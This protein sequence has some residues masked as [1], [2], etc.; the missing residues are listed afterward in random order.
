MI[1][2]GGTYVERTDRPFREEIFGSG[3]R[4]AI[5]LVAL[6]PKVRLISGLDAESRVSAVHIAREYSVDAEWIDR[7]EPVRFRYFTPL[8]APS[9]SGRLASLARDV[10]ASGDAALVFG[11]IE[12]PPRKIEV[13]R[14]VFDPQQPGDILGLDV[15]GLKAE[16]IAYVLNRAEASAVSK[17]PDTERAAVS[18]LRESR[19]E[20]V[21]VKCG[22]QGALLASLDGVAWIGAYPTEQVRPL[23]SGDVFAAGFAHAWA[24][25]GA[26]ALAAARF[27]S[28]A[29]AYVCG[30]ER[31]PLPA[32]FDDWSPTHG[33]VVPTEAPVY[34][35]GPFFT[36]AQQWLVELARTSLSGL[37]ATVFSPLHDVGVGGPQVARA[38]LEGLARCRSVLAL[39]DGADS[40][41][42]FEV[43]WAHRA[44]IPVIGYCEPQS[45]CELKMAV[46]NDIEV[47]TD[48]STA[49]YRAI[50]AAM[51]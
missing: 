44:G 23:G 15:E 40:G 17:D 46:G 36:L 1:V 9:I 6:D 38:D 43:G 26:D 35:A 39:L 32:N 49:V 31:L 33:E 2:V 28:R 27:G 10:V 18:I 37:G 12:R 47:H 42:W 5:A 20:A 21:V 25:N 3:L 50:W 4:A 14:L 8:S 22:A 29:A 45:Q 30:G 7:T 34:L 16:Q 19:A 11:M 48:L 51:E 13:G 41:T 24:V